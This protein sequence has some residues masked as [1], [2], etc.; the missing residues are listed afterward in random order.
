MNRRL[1]SSLLPL[2]VALALT[3]C[4]NKELCYD[5]MEH[6]TRYESRV[7]ATYELIWE[8]P[9][10]DGHNW[11]ANWPTHFD[12]EHSSFN[13]DMPDGLC[14]NAYGA[15]GR[16]NQ[17][18]LKPQGG[19]VEMAPGENALLMYNDDTEYIV[20]D[21]LNNS[22]SAKATTRARS[23]SGFKG[24]MLNTQNGGE[25][26]NTVSAPDP[27]FG[28][29]HPRYVQQPIMEPTEINVMLRPLVF[30]Y[31]VRFEF[32]HGLEYLGVAR[33]AMSGMAGSVYLFDG[34]TGN[35]KATILYDC[36][37]T[38]WGVEAFVNS[39]G[40]PNYPNNSY[41][42]GSDFY[43]ISLE[44]RLKNGKALQ[45]DFDVSEQVA[46]QPHGGVVTVSGIEIDDDA[47]KEDG[48]GFDVTV[49]GWGEFE[50]VIIDM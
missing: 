20:F 28:Y 47:G 8:M 23:R 10:T 21:N 25:A 34:H 6:A 50:D 3:S 1:F 5:H 29:Y 37:I 16:N 24:N 2:L 45:F 31:Y 13:P 33:G 7:V 49:E 48:S 43:G 17:R 14:V 15:D 41:S 22:V 42:R 18:H 26:E 12:R 32:A 38:S 39:F 36:D 40:I 46:C 11:A 19:I 27:L 9:E 35:D 44:V 30:G 4:E